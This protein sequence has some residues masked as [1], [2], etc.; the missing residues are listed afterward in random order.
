MKILTTVVKL[1]CS[2]LLISFI[3]IIATFFLTMFMP[4]E[5]QYAIDFFRNLLQVK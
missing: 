4:E 1:V 3:A 5:V 2:V